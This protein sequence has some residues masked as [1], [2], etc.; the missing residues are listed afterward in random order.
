MDKL[1]ELALISEQI[2][3]KWSTF[4]QEGYS[5]ENFDDLNSSFRSLIDLTESI[6]IENPS[7]QVGDVLSSVMFNIVNAL[8]LAQEYEQECSALS[9]MIW[10]SYTKVLKQTAAVLDESIIHDLY[11][12]INLHCRDGIIHMINEIFYN[13]NDQTQITQQLIPQLKLLSFFIQRLIAT[14]FT[15]P[16]NLLIREY[17]IQ[18]VII[19]YGFLQCLFNQIPSSNSSTVSNT[20]TVVTTCSSLL[21]SWEQNTW[22]SLLRLFSLSITTTTTNDTLSNN[23]KPN[24]NATNA[25]DYK[26]ETSHQILSIIQIM[27][28]D[29]WQHIMTSS[30]YIF[31]KKEE[32]HSNNNN[33]NHNETEK[34]MQLFHQEF[35]IKTRVFWITGY[36]RFL[37]SLLSQ[38]LSFYQQPAA[39]TAVV[40]PTTTS[41]N[42]TMSLDHS[43]NHNLND[44]T[45][46]S[47]NNLSPS[48]SFLISWIES[49]VY[50]GIQYQKLSSFL[51]I[52]SSNSLS[53]SAILQFLETNS[54]MISLWKDIQL[55]AQLISCKLKYLISM[56]YYEEH[57]Q[58]LQVLVSIHC[59][60]T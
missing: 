1:E 29:Y 38:T 18:L 32:G 8:Y 9:A 16:S 39:H 22:K 58:T 23:S 36:H 15:F 30:T 54:S 2:S 33:H 12:I 43:I 59:L 51:Q 10:K 3:S 37:Q 6:Q 55:I 28:I 20:N 31:M 4:E 34:D 5:V 50:W 40:A 25:A 44:N 41:S 57:D 45:I 35:I 21:V 19:Y 17:S 52:N 48:N 11:Q 13:H 49:L 47:A 14:C 60:V 7:T 46:S 53:H 42:D 56:K 24:I 26:L 27:N